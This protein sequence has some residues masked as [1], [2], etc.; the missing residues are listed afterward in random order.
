MLSG[1]QPCP[2]KAACARGPWDLAGE[3]SEGGTPPRQRGAARGPPERAATA[4]VRRRFQAPPGRLQRGREGQRGSRARA[5]R[6]QE[7][8]RAG[9]GRARGG[10]RRAR[11]G[12]RA[13]AAR[14]PPWAPARGESAAGAVTPG[15]DPVQATPHGGPAKGESERAGEREAGGRQPQAPEGPNEVG[16]AGPAPGSGPGGERP[17]SR[18]GRG[19]A[20]RPP[21]RPAGPRRR[22]RSRA[23]RRPRWLRPGRGA[24]GDEGP[25]HGTGVLQRPRLAEGVEQRRCA[26]VRGGACEGPRRPLLRA[27][28]A[29]D[30]HSH[31]RGAVPNSP[32]RLL[33]FPSFKRGICDSRGW[34]E[35]GGARRGG[36]Y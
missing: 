28:G 31:F 33:V 24:V 21:R 20:P 5:G 9:A 36:G 27:T 30:G 22:H 13:R 32:C 19:S 2:R 1:G 29:A 3:Q 14:A 4:G 17:G 6:N 18:S 35:P 26:C 25:G 10:G 11:P 23:G 15:G 7:A 12:L 16:A 8:A 34:G